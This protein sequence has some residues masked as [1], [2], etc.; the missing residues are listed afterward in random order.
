MI[1]VFIGTKAQLI[2]MAPIMRALQDSQ[3]E[4]NFIF[5]GQHQNTIDSLRENFGIKEPDIILH[6]GKDIVGIIQM[7]FWLI[8]ILYKA[9]VAR[10]KIWRGDK[11]GIVL[12]HGDTFS[13]L[14][15][16]LL[17]KLSGRKSVH[18]ES[19][20]RSF[21]IFHPFPEELTR[22]LV[23]RIS[24]YYFCPNEWAANNL[25]GYSGEKI[26]TGGNTLYDALRFIK[27]NTQSLSVKIPSTPYV[28]VSVHRFENIFNKTVLSKIVEIIEKIALTIPVLMI[29]HKPTMQ[30][31]QSFG[32][33]ARLESNEQIEVRP[34][35]DYA[36][37]IHL[38]SLS[39]FVVT[40]GGSNQEEC[41]YL[42]KPCL[43]LRHA[44]ERTEG[45][46]EN[47][48]ISEFD[49]ACIDHFVAHYS[50]YARDEKIIT[51]SPTEVIVDRLI[52][53]SSL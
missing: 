2:K 6:S 29:A 47:V 37:F 38:V 7:G 11:K 53:I 32:L 22:I 20:L 17:A 26:I 12:N 49:Q 35:Y 50:I 48:V 45:L 15:G 14:V 28:V 31:L 46:N 9:A 41:F 42:G 40:D 52:E 44:T 13:T 34:R 18:I 27:K 19:G 33:S 4:Y 43:V 51:P 21:N 25:Q 5:S 39:E 24:A 3:I 36:N 23:F 1:H 16:A 30:K 8:K 10:K